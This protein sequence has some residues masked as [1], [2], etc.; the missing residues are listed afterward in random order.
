[1][2][3]RSN[4]FIWSNQLWS[5]KILRQFVL[6]SVCYWI[7]QNKAKKRKEADLQTTLLRGFGE[8]V[9]KAARLF[10]FQLGADLSLQHKC[11]NLKKA[12]L[13]TGLLLELEDIIVWISCME[14]APDIQSNGFNN[15]KFFPFITH[16]AHTK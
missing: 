7:W 6:L 4:A 2:E 3:H 13:T 11:F 14:N 5:S 15:E 16:F 12:L 10:V 8:G 9:A 1:M